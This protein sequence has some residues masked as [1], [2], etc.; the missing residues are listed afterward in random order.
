MVDVGNYQ[1]FKHAPEIYQSKFDSSWIQ[2]LGQ[3]SYDIGEFLDILRQIEYKGSVGLQACGLGGGPD[4]D[5]RVHLE[6]SMKV[7]KE[8]LK[9]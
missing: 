8:I 9:K 7:W 5:A 4:G 1:W 6:Q 3:G 2:P